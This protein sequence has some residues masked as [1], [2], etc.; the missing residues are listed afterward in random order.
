MIASGVTFI[1]TVDIGLVVQIQGQKP[2]KCCD[3]MRVVSTLCLS[4]IKSTKLT[5]LVQPPLKTLCTKCTS[6]CTRI[7][8][9]YLNL[10]CTMLHQGTSYFRQ[11]KFS[12][13]RTF[14][15]MIKKSEI[16]KVLCNPAKSRNACF[17]LVHLPL[18]PVVHH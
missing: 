4:P 6:I 8:I 9:G 10:K 13:M 7:A 14:E 11:V 2:D 18:T 15:V 3:N 5:P 16:R 12:C 17:H 1:A